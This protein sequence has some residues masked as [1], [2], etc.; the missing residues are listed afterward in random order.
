MLAIVVVTAVELTANARQSS[1]APQRPKL[2]IQPAHPTQLDAAALT[3]LQ[4]DNVELK[5]QVHEQSD[6][7]IAL[8]RDL[9]GATA[10]LSDV[11]G[12]FFCLIAGL[13]SW[14]SCLSNNTDTHHCYHYS[15]PHTLWALTAATILADAAV[16]PP[17]PK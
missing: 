3:Q 12:R 6:T 9:A 8:R 17:S 16:T 10:R 5:T 14:I 4:K 7:I 15:T 13:F 1:P 11:T 2:I